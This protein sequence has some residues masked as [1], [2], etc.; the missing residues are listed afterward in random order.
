MMRSALITGISGFVGSHLAGHLLENGWKVTGYDLLPPRIKCDF[1][2]GN[3][4]DKTALR[5][6]LDDSAPDVVFHLAGILKSESHEDLYNVHVLGTISLLEV[7]AASGLSPKVFIAS[8]GAVYGA[9]MGPKPI[10]ERFSLKPQTHY[11][12]SKAL[13]EMTALRYFRVH[14]MQVVCART[15]NLLGPGL[16]RDLACSA[17]ARQIALAETTGRPATISTGSLSAKR[18]FVDV[19]DAVRAYGLIAKRGKPGEV[20]NVCSGEAV[21]ISEC[22]DILLKQA[23]VPV[24]AVLDPAKV[25]KNDV[26]VQI[27]SVG[28]LKDATGWSPRIALKRS[29]VDL[30]NDWRQRVDMEQA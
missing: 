9:G 8:S 30:L 29:L 22:L 10:T 26:P 3:L 16:S 11:A 6:A 25:Q 28:K 21:S 17:F 7:M 18:D 20:Y 13:Q 14:G 24:E 23:K 15:F 12:L 19:R 2:A 4:A 1:Y 27:G 5:R